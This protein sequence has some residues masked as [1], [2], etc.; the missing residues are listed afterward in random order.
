[1]F[2]RCFGLVSR[3]HKHVVLVVGDVVKGR[4][5]VCLPF[6]L[7]PDTD[8]LDVPSLNMR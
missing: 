1:M 2:C 7:K 3:Y 4:L 6:V 8:S 5:S